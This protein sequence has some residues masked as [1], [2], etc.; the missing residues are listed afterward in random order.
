MRCVCMALAGLL[1]CGAGVPL[2]GQGIPTRRIVVAEQPAAVLNLREVVRLGSLDGEHDAFGRVMD[3]TLDS[4]GRI[5]VADDLAHHVVVFGP[6]GRHLRTLGR[7]GRGPGEFESPWKVAV[8]AQDSIFAWDMALGRV[9]VFAPDLGYVRSFPMPPQWIVNSLAFLPDGRLLVAAYARGSEGTLHLLSRTGRVERSFGPGFNAPD[10][11]GF[12]SSLLGGTLDVTADAIVYS[13][14]SPYEI[15]FFGLDGRQRSR[16]VGRPEWTAEPAS[17]VET[18][19][20]GRALQW[21]RF[22]HSSKV[23]GLGGGLLMNQVLDPSGD[24]SFVD[25]LTADCRLLRR[26]VLSPP[27]TLTS[28]SG[29]RLV[30]VR[31]LEFPEIVVYEQRVVRD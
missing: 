8:D 18:R 26:T 30:G 1:A 31:N 4:R 17:V 10:L 16:C 12:E 5:I 28:R 21:Q 23:V 2:A 25:I 19:A 6:D 13:T 29:T 24:R 7:Q 22:V 20:E 14:K 27:M 11:A 15:W 3:A 9:S